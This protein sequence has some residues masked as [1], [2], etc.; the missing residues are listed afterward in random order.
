MKGFECKQNKFRKSS[1]KKYQTIQ[2]LR[3][4]RGFS[5]AQFCSHS[6]DFQDFCLARLTG[7]LWLTGET[8]IRQIP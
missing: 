5:F 3:V 6:K 1:V 2:I 4:L 7:I 8:E